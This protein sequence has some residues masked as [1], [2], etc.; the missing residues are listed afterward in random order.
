M[1]RLTKDNLDE[2]EL[3]DP[4][5]MVSI[6]VSLWKRTPKGFQETLSVEKRWRE[7]NDEEAK[8]AFHKESKKLT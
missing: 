4:R 8:N 3:R 2:D 5:P 7:L 1:R 6:T